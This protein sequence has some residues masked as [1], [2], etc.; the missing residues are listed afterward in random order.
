MT[1]TER[2]GW[3]H[4]GRAAEH[5]ARRV[6]HD[7]RRFAARVEEHVGEFARDVRH[8]WRCGQRTAWR[9]EG[10]SA[11]DVRRIFADVRGVL[12]AVLDGV[13][14]FI[15]GVFHETTATSWTRVVLN[16]DATCGRCARSIPA[17]HEAHVRG[18][19]ERREFRCLDCGVQPAADA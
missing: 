14:E 19:A 2:G 6:A 3:E 7:A 11:D 8:E 16:R 17:G 13:D 18:S 5:L 15:S 1:T 4:F 9:G 12:S 10:A